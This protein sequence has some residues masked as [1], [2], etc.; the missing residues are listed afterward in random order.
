MADKEKTKTRKKDW[1]KRALTTYEFKSLF[2]KKNMFCPICWTVFP[3]NI[4]F[5]SIYTLNCL[6]RYINNRH[7]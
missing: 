3:I 6:K 4:K 7:A 5:G 1:S 2:V